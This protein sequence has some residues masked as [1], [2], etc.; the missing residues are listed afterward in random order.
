MYIAPAKEARVH[1]WKEIQG[2]LIRY[3]IAG[4]LVDTVWE[5]CARSQRLYNSV[6]NEWDL[7]KDLDPTAQPQI[8]AYGAYDDDNDG[9]PSFTG[10]YDANNEPQLQIDTQDDIAQI[11]GPSE[12]IQEKSLAA[13]EAWSL[14]H[15]LYLRYGFINDGTVGFPPIELTFEK[16]VSI[17]AEGRNKHV[18]NQQINNAICNFIRGFIDD[19]Q[20]VLV[21]I[22][23]IHSRNLCDFRD[24]CN[25]TFTF[26]DKKDYFIT[27]LYPQ[28]THRSISY[29][30][31]LSLPSLYSF[32]A[33]PKQL[34]CLQ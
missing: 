14:L 33:T 21:L 20:E 26:T 11:Y 3:F 5:G 23:D 27:S 28:V 25:K 13:L 7:C 6:R 29:A 2:H 8:T 4:A 12:S 18:A 9:V 32:C 31:R 24:G 30:R 16:A 1:E 15:A 19:K 22:H 34:I 10:I 17:L